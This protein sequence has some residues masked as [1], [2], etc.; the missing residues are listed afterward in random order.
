MPLSIFLGI[1]IIASWIFHVSRGLYHCV[2][3]PD[4]IEFS[5]NWIQIARK[6]HTTWFRVFIWALTKVKFVAGQVLG[7]HGIWDSYFYRICRF[8][9]AVCVLWVEMDFVLYSRSLE[10]K[11]CNLFTLIFN[12]YGWWHGGLGSLCSRFVS[13]VFCNSSFG[14]SRIQQGH[15]YK[16]GDCSTLR[17]ST[18][19]H[20]FVS[21]WPC[22][23]FRM[24]AVGDIAFSF[25]GTSFGQLTWLP[26]LHGDVI[27]LEF[28]ITRVCI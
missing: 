12:M 15:L 14:V 17:E 16:L 25:H 18:P 6:L 8:T 21:I 22:L 2:Y 23:W 27:N 28:M 24:L 11:F 20:S 5:L 3:A 4:D 13:I 10:V 7:Y 19:W 26:W 1:K 9:G